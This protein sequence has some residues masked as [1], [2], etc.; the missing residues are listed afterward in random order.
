VLAGVLGRRQARRGQCVEAASQIYAFNVGWESK[1][2]L[3]LDAHQPL[4]FLVEMMYLKN[5]V[6][7]IHPFR[8]STGRSLLSAENS[9]FPR[10]QWYQACFRDLQPS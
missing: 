6:P 10:K 2:A 9:L 5:K 4:M 1:N 8:T 7:T 3:L